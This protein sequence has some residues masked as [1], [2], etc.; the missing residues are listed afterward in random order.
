MISLVQGEVAVRRP[1][2]VV[3]VCAGVGYRLSVSA[4]TLRQLPAPG[5]EATLHAHL[6]LRDDG[7]QLYGFASELERELFLMLISV[8]SVGPK[9]A[10]AVLSGG[11]AA[12]LMG[13]LAAGDAGRFEAAPGVGRRTAQRIV[14]ELREKAGM[15]AAEIG[16]IT[17]SRVDDPRRVAR[18]GLI[19]LGIPAPEA[20]G[21]LEGVA[22][23]TPED[24]I[25]QALRTAPS[26][27][28]RPSR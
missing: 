6:I 28:G 10:L 20:D 5:A 23:D 1:D 3:V 14:S 25:S 22:G 11:P 8:P 19:E 7:I 2:H 17:A 21:L 15:P 16:A 26:G 9:V 12:E 24:L 18:D 13:A 4:Q 27:G